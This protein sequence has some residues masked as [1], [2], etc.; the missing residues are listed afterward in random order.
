MLGVLEPSNT[1]TALTEGRRTGGHK[2]FSDPENGLALL[3]GNLDSVKNWPCPPGK[4]LQR[5]KKC[6]WPAGE[7]PGEC[8]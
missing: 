3:E 2:G 5:L 6:P 4:D 7:E 1:G 8:Q